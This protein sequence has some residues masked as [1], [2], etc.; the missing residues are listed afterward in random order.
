MTDTPQTTCPWCGRPADK[1]PF[2]HDDVRNT[3]W[4]AACYVLKMRSVAATL[5]AEVCDVN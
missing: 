1:A 4:H 3:N 2:V 5:K